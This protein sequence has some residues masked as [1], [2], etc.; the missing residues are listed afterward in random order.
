MN[1][2]HIKTYTLEEVLEAYK[3]FMK[4]LQSSKALEEIEGIVGIGRG[5]LF[6]AQLV[7]YDLNLPFIY[8]DPYSSKYIKQVKRI[9]KKYSGLLVLDDVYE[10]GKTLN[11]FDNH[12]YLF[13][14]KFKGVLYFGVLYYRRREFAVDEKGEKTM[15]Y[16]V[17][18]HFMYGERVSNTFYLHF[19]WERY[20]LH[21]QIKEAAN[22]EIQ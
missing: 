7:A 22:S 19:P 11:V 10:S 5:S 20:M 12:M 9:S 18:K 8:V 4:K 21:Q 6:F 15:Q 17:P 13:N 14:E 3:T 1:T 16:S 2:R